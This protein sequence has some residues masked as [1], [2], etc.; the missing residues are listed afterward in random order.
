MGPEK[1]T[2]TSM[3]RKWILKSF[4]N[5]YFQEF[6][7]ANLN[8]NEYA[9]DMDAKKINKTNMIRKWTLQS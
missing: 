3:F 7:N 9:Q 5:E 8:K 6:D 2:Q 4:N 1:Q